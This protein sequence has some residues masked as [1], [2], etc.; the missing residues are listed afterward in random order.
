MLVDVHAHLHLPQFNEDRAEVIK[1]ASNVL[2]IE[3]GL[4]PESNRKVRIIF[5]H[6][7]KNL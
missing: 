7:Q 4:D 1:R 5:R 3:N 2:I 6:L